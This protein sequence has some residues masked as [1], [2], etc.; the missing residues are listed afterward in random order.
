[1]PEEHHE[2]GQLD[3]AEEVFDAIFPSH[4]QSAVVL[5]PGEDSLDLPSAPVAAQWPAVL[6][7]L[8]AVGSVARP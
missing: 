1:M 2:A 5:H 7:F 8:L 3:E 6:G 4:N